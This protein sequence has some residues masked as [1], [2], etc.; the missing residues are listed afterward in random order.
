[1]PGMHDARE[2]A[3]TGGGC[4]G[5]VFRGDATSAE[6]RSL[7]QQTY[8]PNGVPGFSLAT[9]LPLHAA[10]AERERVARSEISVATGW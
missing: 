3:E 6:R 2:P 10:P 7:A 5:A 9:T 1:M 4:Y 8:L